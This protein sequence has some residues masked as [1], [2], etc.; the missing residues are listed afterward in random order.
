METRSNV[1]IAIP[2]RTRDA[3]TLG[4]SL[5]HWY[6]C[7]LF[8]HVLFSWLSISRAVE[9]KLNTCRIP[10]KSCSIGCYNLEK[11]IGQLVIV[12]E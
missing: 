7:K 4:T 3:T 2:G 11:S 6:P 8:F 10:H 12:F 1:M 5:N 9:K